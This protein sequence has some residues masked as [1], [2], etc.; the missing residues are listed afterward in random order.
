[1][2]VEIA[3]VLRTRMYAVDYADIALA[4]EDYAKLEGNASPCLACDGSPCARACPNGIPIAERARW[5][6][7]M[8]GA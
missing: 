1:V 4:R 3:Q 7:R 2:G 8:L 5:T 6:D